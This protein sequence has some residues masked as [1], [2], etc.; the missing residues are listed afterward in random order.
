MRG[1]GILGC[2]AMI[3]FGARA[4]TADTV[5]IG[6]TG[7]ALAA[8]SLLG[9]R[10]SALEPDTR[11]EVLPSFGNTGGI[12]ALIAGAI[13]VAV[14]SRPLEAAERASG[15]Q[16]ELIARTPLAVVTHLSNRDEAI[17][18]AELAAIYAGERTTWPNGTPIRLVIRPAD[19]T[20]TLLLRSLSPEMDA[21]VALALQRPGFVLAATDQENAQMIERVAG[22]IGVATL[23]QLAAEDRRLNVMMLDGK[24]PSAE[25]ANDPDYPLTKDLYIVTRQTPTAA[26]AGFVRFIRAPDGDDILSRNDFVT[27][28]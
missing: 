17:T 10:F 26:V 6:G 25:A 3:G 14:S 8:M 5:R 19:D 13:D 7:T 24:R 22:S 16:A 9:E 20:D 27:V 11:I 4:A 1:V 23:G 2:I 12:K 28:E 21:A 15:V 18:I